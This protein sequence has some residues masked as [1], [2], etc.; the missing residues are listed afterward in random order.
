M[1]RRDAGEWTGIRRRCRH[2]PGCVD[3]G[4]ATVEFALVLPVVALLVVGL[5]ELAAVTG[6]QVVAVDAARAGARAAAVD[7]RPEVA[8]AAVQTG[9]DAW[10]VTTDV[11]AGTPPMVTVSVA[12][13]VR[14]LP[15]LGW[16]T[17]HLEATSTMAVESTD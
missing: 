5:V 7:P 11:L 16:S 13:S 14:L 4:Q 17:V 3:R 2:E 9:D 10:T 12:R 6:L 1:S 15:G 8:E